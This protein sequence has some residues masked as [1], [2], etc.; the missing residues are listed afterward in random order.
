MRNLEEF[1]THVWM[2]KRAERD[3]GKLPFCP[4]AVHS[5]VKIFTFRKSAPNI[6]KFPV[7]F[8]NLDKELFLDKIQS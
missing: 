3:L 7:F 5:F 8:V 6:V 1:A 4:A 2:P